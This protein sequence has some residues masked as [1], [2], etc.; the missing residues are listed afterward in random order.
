MTLKSISPDMLA[1]AGTL[2]THTRACTH[3]LVETQ[4]GTC[5]AAPFMAFGQGMKR[6]MMSVPCNDCITATQ[7]ETPPGIG[8]SRAVEGDLSGAADSG[9]E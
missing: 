9:R 4:D 7:P 3:F 5:F 6:R 2:S 1:K 8:R